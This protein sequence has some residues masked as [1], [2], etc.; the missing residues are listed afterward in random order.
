MRWVTSYYTHDLRSP[1]RQMSQL[2]KLQAEA[3]Q[4]RRPSIENIPPEALARIGS[5]PASQA[6]DAHV[7]SE[8]FQSVLADLR[9]SALHDSHT[10]YMWGGLRVAYF[11]GECSN[12]NVVWGAW[13][14]EAAAKEAGGGLPMKFKMMKAANHFVSNLLHAP[15][16]FD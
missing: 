16:R 7:C 12:W 3:D 11:W 8:G 14:V 10:A 13:M 5:F 6:A 2:R 15:L 4:H 9:R 1:G